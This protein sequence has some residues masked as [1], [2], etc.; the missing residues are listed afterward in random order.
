[1]ALAH[2]SSMPVLIGPACVSRLCTAGFKSFAASV[3]LEILP[4]LAGLV[5]PNGCGNSNVVDVPR[6]AM[7]GG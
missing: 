7:G 2:S 6:W 1:M 3:A 5:G 4:R